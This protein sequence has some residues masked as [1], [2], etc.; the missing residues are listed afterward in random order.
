MG[1]YVGVFALVFVATMLA[2]LISG[3]VSAKKLHF[4]IPDQ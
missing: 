2:I 1:Q 3:S 4:G